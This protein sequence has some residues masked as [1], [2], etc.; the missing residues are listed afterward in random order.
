MI[1]IFGRFKILFLAAFQLK[2]TCKYLQ[3]LTSCFDLLEQ[4]DNIHMSAWMQNGGIKNWMV[5]ELVGSSLKVGLPLNHPCFP[6]RW[7]SLVCLDLNSKSQA[8]E[9]VECVWTPMT[10][11]IWG[12]PHDL[13]LWPSVII[14]KYE[15]IYTFYKCDYK[16]LFQHL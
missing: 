5:S 3:C 7:G 11:M 1:P 6:T 10:W 13:Q 2:M 12:Y 8:Q 4:R 9:A 14:G 16:I 15:I